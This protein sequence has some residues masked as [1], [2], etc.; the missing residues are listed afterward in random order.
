M[1]GSL[2]K[3]IMILTLIILIVIVSIIHIFRLVT[4][5]TIAPLLGIQYMT[6]VG[7]ELKLLLKL[8]QKLYW[9]NTYSILNIY[10][11]WNKIYTMKTYILLSYFFK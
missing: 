9:I 2:R 1:R 4:H 6:G 7:Q 3:S 8:I 11:I 10:I 5:N